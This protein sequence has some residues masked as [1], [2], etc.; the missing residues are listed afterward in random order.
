MSAR[1]AHVVGPPT[2]PAHDEFDTPA[3]LRDVGRLVRLLAP[4]LAKELA[5]LLPGRDSVP[6][7]DVSPRPGKEK[8]TWRSEGE[9]NGSSDPTLSENNGESSWSDVEA[10]EIVTSIRRKK[11]RGK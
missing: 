8:E 6:G 3:G 4:L 7:A 9:G 11:K 1:G 2:A 10:K 5:P